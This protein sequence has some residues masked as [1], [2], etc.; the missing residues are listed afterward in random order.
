MSEPHPGPA[1]IMIV[2]DTP[3]NLRLLESMLREQGYQVFAL[4]S[5]ERA[6]KAAER[7]PP[8]LI[9]LDVGMPGL[10]GYQVCE[11][12]KADPELAEIPILFLSGLTE[13]ADKVKAFQAGGLDYITKPFQFEEV[14]AR[15][16]AHL[17]V[18]QQRQ[19]LAEGLRR[20][21][22]LEKLRD[23]L[24]HMIVHDMRSPLAG[25]CGFLEL[26]LK[27]GANR[28]DPKTLSDL[29]AALDSG[30]GLM[31]MV[32]TLLDVNKFEEGKM[33]L[34]IQAGDLRSV[35][36]VALETL[37]E[38]SRK[39]TIRVIAPAEPVLA[40]FDAEII[41]RVVVNLV[42]NAVKFSPSKGDVRVELKRDAEGIRFSVADTG[43]GIPQEYYQVIFEKFGHVRE[44]PAGRRYSTG[45]G[46][47]FCRLAI[48]AHG[49][50]IGVD[51][52]VGKGS[53]FW[54]TLPAAA[55]GR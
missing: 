13:T 44:P 53:T 55:A 23:N 46:L 26:A 8:D 30:R 54:F 29:G 27:S 45:L 14:Q 16:R 31:R 17:Q 5:G 25:L 36:P 7:N 4:P 41:R 52:T 21:Q 20:L 35:V 51:S 50:Q 1:R 40:A 12:L 48:E 39:C 42:D 11:R 28:L 38:L 22:E 32:N 43:P 47:T 18:R 19:D 9:L 37:G 33:P 3:E 10:N 34:A 49:G 6:L 2:D 24:V 15:V